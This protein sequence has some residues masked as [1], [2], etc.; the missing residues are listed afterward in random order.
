MPP[1]VGY[2][3]GQVPR[4]VKC[5]IPGPDRN[6]S[7]S[8]VA[9]SIESV[10]TIEPVAEDSALFRF[11]A[12]VVRHRRWAL[13]GDNLCRRL[14]VFSIHFD[15]A[16]LARIKDEWAVLLGQVGLLAKL[17]VSVVAAALIFSDAALRNRFRL[18]AE[19]ADETR[20]AWGWVMLPTF[21]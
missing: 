11:A 15:T 14:I 3:V 18:A 16:A 13:L 12:G 1:I 7:L 5:L 21:Y 10:S 2:V 6:L 9:D 19:R 17:A 8:V 4:L 20:L